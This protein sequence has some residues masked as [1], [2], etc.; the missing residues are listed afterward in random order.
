MHRLAL[1]WAS[2][3][4]NGLDAVPRQLPMF[5]LRGDLNIMFTTREIHPPTRIFDA[6]FAFVGAS[7]DPAS[8][9]ER[10]DFSGL[11]GERIVYLSLGT[12][13][14]T[15][16]GLFRRTMAALA[17]LP[18]RLLVSA[19]PGDPARFGPLPGNV[20]VHQSFPQ[21]DVLAGA[22]AFITHAG[23]NSI[24][25]SLWA[26]VPMVAVPQQF[27]QLRNALTV[28][29]RGAGI[30]LPDEAYRQP[31]SG[32]AL[33]QALEQVLNDPIYAEKARALGASLHAAGGYRQAAERIETLLD[34]N[35]TRP[36]KHLA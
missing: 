20:I 33:R 14:H 30:T 22:D 31:V 2:I 3:L 27:E 7:I 35:Q 13:H 18:I 16:D 17:D 28:S 10:F 8:R 32:D 24:H 12:L 36:V 26:G 25:E 29:R 9:P 6:S 4:R 5:P 34:L 15:N 19:G 1:G 11:S 23:L 21:L